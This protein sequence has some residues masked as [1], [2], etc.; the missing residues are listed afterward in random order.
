[1]PEYL[2]EFYRPR[3]DARAASDDGESARAA[4]E[5]LTRR[6]T[7]VAYRRAI[8]VPSEETCFLLFEADS[9]D[10]VRDAAAL[11]ALPCGRITAVSPQTPAEPIK[12]RGLPV[13]PASAAATAA[14]EL[15][16]LTSETELGTP[17]RADIP[18]VGPRAFPHEH[19][20]PSRGEATE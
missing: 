9:A 6:G 1:M 19:Q 14:T 20:R 10:A 12:A 11:A 4:A 16:E 2:L 18:C 7:A 5:E 17:G 15:T 13:L 8:F 3:D